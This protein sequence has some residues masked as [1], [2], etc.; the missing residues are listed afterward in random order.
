MPTKRELREVWEKRKRLADEIGDRAR[1]TAEGD[2]QPFD[3]AEFMEAR[4]E[5]DAA[6]AEYLSAPSDETDQTRDTK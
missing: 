6:Q 2:A 5:A 4:R 3:E 1:E